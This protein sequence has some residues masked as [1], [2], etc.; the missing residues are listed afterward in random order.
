MKKSTAKQIRDIANRLPKV[1]EQHMS[2]GLWDTDETGKDEFVP[3]VYLVEVNHERRLRKA[4]ER[5]GMDGIKSYLDSIQKLQKDR[6]EK[7][8]GNT[9]SGEAVP[10]PDKVDPIGNNNLLNDESKNTQSTE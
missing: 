10:V 2:G 4:Y 9:S 3:N 8:F 7:A 1:M 5:M 6:H